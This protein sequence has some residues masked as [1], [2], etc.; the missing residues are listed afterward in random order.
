MDKKEKIEFIK[1][2]RKIGYCIYL[3][4]NQILSKTVRAFQRHFRKELINGSIDK[5]CFLIAENLTKK[6]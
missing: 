6:L 3:G 5:E 4:N 2:L 1:N